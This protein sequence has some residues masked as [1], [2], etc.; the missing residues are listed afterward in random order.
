MLDSGHTIEEI[1]QV[2]GLSEEYI[3]ANYT[4]SEESNVVKELKLKSYGT[5]RETS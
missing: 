4:E 2:T 5:N 1:T 3:H